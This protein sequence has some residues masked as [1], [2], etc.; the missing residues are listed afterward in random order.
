MKD[1]I[2]AYLSRKGKDGFNHQDLLGILLDL[3]EAGIET[4][5]ATLSWALMH[6]ALNQEEQEDCFREIK[7]ALGDRSPTWEDRMD[8]PVCRATVMEVQRISYVTPGSS[9]HTCSKDTN[10]AG[11]RIPKGG[12]FPPSLKKANFNKS[13]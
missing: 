12:L 5:S 7:R 9:D 2:D 3:F 4:V 13:S 1:L 6:L 11:Y 8:M 10:I